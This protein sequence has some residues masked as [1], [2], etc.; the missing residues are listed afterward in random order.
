[1]ESVAQAPCESEDAAQRFFVRAGHLV[2]LAYV[3]GATDL[4]QENIIA[5]DEQPVPIDLETLMH[6]VL[7]AEPDD[8]SAA[9]VQHLANRIVSLSVMRSGLLPSW[10]IDEKGKVH[11]SS[12]L[13]ASID[14]AAPSTVLRW[15][16]INSDAMAATWE[17]APDAYRPNRLIL[18]GQNLPAG[19][20]PQQI[21]DGFSSMYRFLRLHRRDSAVSGAVAAFSG[22]RLRF[23]ARPTGAYIA[24][25]ERGLDPALLRSG[26]DRS[27]EFDLLA[28]G[29][30]HEKPE[31]LCRVFLRAELEALEQ[32]DVPHF[33]AISDQPDL[34]VSRRGADDVVIEG[35]LEQS[36]YDCLLRS[37]ER[38]DEDDLERQASVIRTTLY[39]SRSEEMHVQPF[40]RP[41]MIAREAGEVSPARLE[42]E[43]GAIAHELKRLAVTAADGSVTWMGLAYHLKARRQQIQPL[44]YGLYDGTGG[45]ALFLS[46]LEAVTGQRDFHDLALGCLS[47][48]QSLLGDP[49][50][51]APFVEHVG[52]GGATGLGSIIYSLVRSGVA[53]GEDW[54][55]RCASLSA[56]LITDEA[57]SSD[58][59]FDV[60]SG[61]AG[62]ILG[63][64]SLGGRDGTGM[65]RAVACGRYLLKNSTAGPRGGRAWPTLGGRLLTG[66]SHGAAGIA[67][68]LLRLF[69][70]TGETTFRDAA[71]EA[72]AYER[73]VFLQEE[74]NWPD[75][76]D[77]QSNLGPSP[78]AWCHGAVGIGIA[79]LGSLDV[80]HD[81]RVLGEI[82]MAC[83]TTCSRPLSELHNLCCGNL[84]R[85][86]LLLLASQRLQR[87]EY[88]LLARNIAGQRLSFSNSD[89]PVSQRWSN[90][91]FDLGLFQGLSGAGYELLRLANPNRVPSV[92][93]WESESPFHS[94]ATSG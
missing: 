6:P 39:A 67:Y 21:V 1:V 80:L 38:L 29:L 83:Q 64:L 85:A 40:P 9:N 94:H 46:T 33:A 20:Y 24:L 59:S 14:N 90:G 66:F 8:A 71:E 37:L 86:E 74:G 79:R 47:P 19:D 30:L 44:G 15:R 72:I 76:R 53:L 18:N 78:C 13:N 89:T 45:I 35:C 11:D 82:E 65:D 16:G 22:Q 55:A 69:Q 51:A 42:E 91:P 93:L 43:A 27:I 63:L 17:A 26:L 7:K 54:P 56:E 12:G 28:R 60:I 3:L 62:A 92:L 70:A 88:A 52:I 2:C 25:L 68:A 50:A 81:T 77:V 31:L 49:A 36:G 57:I 73:S 4:H 34:I 5:C 87:T 23:V 48:L 10:A 41:G 32:L 58:L 75:Y 84:G 61:S